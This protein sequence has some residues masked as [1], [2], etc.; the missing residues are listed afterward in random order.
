LEKRSKRLLQ[1]NFQLVAN[2][3]QLKI[4]LKFF[5]GVGGETSGGFVLKR[6]IL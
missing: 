4:I 2:C 1:N 3:D 6:M 5:G